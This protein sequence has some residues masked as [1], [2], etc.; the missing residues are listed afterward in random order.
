MSTKLTIE[1]NK[2]CFTTVGSDG[3][4]VQG[5]GVTIRDA[6]TDF[7]RSV[8]STLHRPALL[9][10]ETIRHYQFTPDEF[11]YMSVRAFM[12]KLQSWKQITSRLSVVPKEVA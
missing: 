6:M 11:E 5:H 7:N 8:G 2:W 3:K 1:N 12:R 9:S 10:S 4:Q